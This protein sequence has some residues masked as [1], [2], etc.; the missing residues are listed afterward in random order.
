MGHSANEQD[1][2]IAHLENPVVP[3]LYIGFIFRLELVV[4]RNKNLLQH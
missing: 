2:M 3:L 4:V 1:I